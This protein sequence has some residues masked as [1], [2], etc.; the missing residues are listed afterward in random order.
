MNFDG[1]YEG[2]EEVFTLSMPALQWEFEFVSWGKSWKTQEVDDPNGTGKISKT[3]NNGGC[4]T[5][6]VNGE[7][8]VSC[9]KEV[10]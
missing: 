1:S 6:M 4:Y 10:R 5:R 9:Y 3:V 7:K 2:I 8:R